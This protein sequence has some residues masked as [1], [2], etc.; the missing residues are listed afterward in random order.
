MKKSREIPG[1]FVAR[2]SRRSGERTA[3]AEFRSSASSLRT[4]VP[5]ADWSRARCGRRATAVSLPATLCHRDHPRSCGRVGKSF[6]RPLRRSGACRSALLLIVVGAVA[7]GCS[8][9]PSTLKVT[10]T[11]IK[12]ANPAASTK[13]FCFLTGLLDLDTFRLRGPFFVRA[14]KD[15]EIRISSALSVKADLYLCAAAEKAPLVILLHGHEN[16]KDDHVLQALHVAT[17]GMH[18][19]TIDLPNRGPWIANGKTL[20][21]L[22]DAIRRAPD[23][24]DSQIDLSRV[25]LVGHSFGATAVASA[26]AEGADVSG[27]I[28]LDPAGIGRQLPALL[29]KVKVPVMLIG[30]DE[31]I[32]PTRNR[33]YFYRFIPGTVAEI[34]IRHAVHED[35][36]Y[37]DGAPAARTRR[38]SVRDGSITDHVCERADRL[39]IQPHG[40][41]KFRLCLEQFRR[42]VARRQFFQSKEEV[43]RCSHTGHSRKSPSMRAHVSPHYGC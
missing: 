43:T 29:K 4:L 34:S 5:C 40:Y 20:A 22:V 41:G 15:V 33:D 3:S 23:L 25:I 27:A 21:R 6:R 17:W 36:Q 13:E 26:L 35:A 7:A 16:S 24:A 12:A 9:E 1:F 37:P 31:E 38:H 39:R 30:A 19:M 28:L 42:R 10:R 14:L 8:R 18:A 32:W 11:V 2:V